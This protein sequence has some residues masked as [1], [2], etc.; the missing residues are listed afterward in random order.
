MSKRLLG[1]SGT[2][3][4]G[5]GSHCGGGT[6]WLVFSG[7]TLGVVMTS[8]CGKN[9]RAEN[10]DSALSAQTWDAGGGENTPEQSP[11]AGTKVNQAVAQPRSICSSDAWCW[12]GLSSQTNHL[13]AVSV[14]SLADVW[15]VGDHG[16][17]LHFDGVSWNAHPPAISANL[18]AV[19]AS[20]TD[21]WV[22]GEQASLLHYN[23]AT[24]IE[25]KELDLPEDI[26]LHAIWFDGAGGG[27]A[28]G[29]QGVLL[30]LSDGG[31]AQVQVETTESLNAIWGVG[32][33]VWVV[34][35]NG[36]LLH[37]RD[38]QWLAEE[39]GTSRNLFAIAGNGDSVWLAGAS[40]EVRSYDA[41][42][43]QWIS[44]GGDGPRPSG[45]IR[46]LQLTEPNQAYVAGAAGD[47]Y[48]WDGERLCP[49]EG[50]AGAPEEPCPAWV[51]GRH[52]GQSLAL[53]G[54]WAQG[55]QAL[56]V[57][58][59]GL[60]VQWEGSLRTV[61]ARGAEDNYLAVSGADL[62][63]IWV[64]GDQLLHRAEGSWSAVE[65]DSARAVY[66]VQG[67][68][69]GGT[70]LA[71]TGGMSRRLQEEAW[72]SLDVLASAWLRGLASD[73]QSGWL[74]GS[75]GRAWGLLN[76]SLWTELETPTNADLLGVWSL[77]GGATWAV[78][79]SGTILRHN[80]LLWAAV[81]SGPDGNLDV[82]LR[83]VWSSS[84][85]S[86]WAVG[87]GGTLLHYDGSRWTQQGEVTA[88]SFNSVWGRNASDVWA[89]GSGGKVLHYNG[90][91][92]ASEESGTSHTLNGVW[93]SEAELFIVGERET[94]LAKSL[95]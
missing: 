3:R 56:A 86:V 6:Q 66:A 57:G 79:E 54:L 18:F 28:A 69:G 80:G 85:D 64:A 68:P 25:E 74:V 73:G 23:G 45:D 1:V 44:M 83:S 90:E 63:N 55:E 31:W 61:L 19:W 92:W 58:E 16:T 87:T 34:G 53:L 15:A 42:G 75:G 76:G 8:G 10:Q 26:D 94:L 38:G 21:V 78:G 60:S 7:I 93:G 72:Q 24:W 13:R 22:V 82:E 89:V 29:T 36:V 84:D 48:H 77:S 47:I 9:S 12:Q 17:L 33:E 37:L 2:S 41:E 81:P 39:S 35:D 62:E 52:A 40:G 71:G 43:E 70:L 50:D 27:W 91:T 32:S 49:V 46:A 11:D 30:Q 5:A 65:R 95:N 20:E 67:L 59:Y 4:V 14:V 88:V 51:A